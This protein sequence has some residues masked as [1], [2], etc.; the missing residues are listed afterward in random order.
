MDRSTTSL[1]PEFIGE[2][3]LP[4]SQDVAE[5]IQVGLYVLQRGRFNFVN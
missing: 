5:N 1:L 4:I 3:F 2:S